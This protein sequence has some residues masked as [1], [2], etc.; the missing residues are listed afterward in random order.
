MQD[1]IEFYRFK[2]KFAKLVNTKTSSYFDANQGAIQKE[3]KGLIN[4]LKQ[5]YVKIMLKEFPRTCGNCIIDA[6][7]ELNSL[8]INQIVNKMTLL[9]KLKPG[10]LAQIGAE[11]YC[12]Q[13]KHLTN[14][15]CE[16]IHNRY[17]DAW[18]EFYEPEWRSK[19]VDVDVPEL[20]G[21]IT[22]DKLEQFFNI[23]DPVK[24]QAETITDVDTFEKGVI[25]QEQ[26]EIPTSP[27]FDEMTHV[28]LLAYCK[29]NKIKLSS[30]KKKDIVAQL[31]SI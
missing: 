22:V 31:K 1:I 18:F 4:Q 27:N 25:E 20:D 5:Y 17:G 12:N 13:S 10:K 29:E 15:I 2:E 19:Q 9:S 7:F 3:Y 26:A 23:S 30:R 8:N 28:D 14:E 6:F 21:K 11:Y 24:E 16:Q